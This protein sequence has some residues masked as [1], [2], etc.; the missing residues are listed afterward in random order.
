VTD[1]AFELCGETVRL[2]PER[3][4][5]WERQRTLVL[6]DPH[7][8]KADAFRAAA[9][10]VPGATDPALARLGHA[11]DRTGADRLVVLGDFSHA[12]TGRTPRVIAALTDWR[13]A[14]ASLRVELIRGNHDRAGDPPPGWA[15]AWHDAPVPDPPFVL[16]HYPNPAA[17]GYVLAG[18]LHPGIVLAGRGRQRLR[19]PCFW[20]G[21]GVGVLPAFGD[22]TGAMTVRRGAGDRVFAVAGNEVVAV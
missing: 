8:G 19:L 17:G 16:D 20:F 13:R 15:E 2:L 4:L 11:L 18:H 3:C 9:V 10:P 5:F 21:S 6:A 12:R 1:A 14:R 22:F 7:F